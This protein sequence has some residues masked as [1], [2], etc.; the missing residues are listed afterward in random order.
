MA[1]IHQKLYQTKDIS[2]IDFGE[3]T[4]TV[5]KY[6][7]HSYGILHDKVKIKIDVQKTVMSIDSA[8]PAGLI[9]NELVSN[10]LKHAFP[11]ERKGN[12]FI[13]MAYD[14]FK[15]EYWLV[16]RDDGVGM[17]QDFDVKSSTSFGLK[18]VSTLVEQM[19]GQIELVSKGGC[20]YR[21]T[22]KS[23]DYTDRS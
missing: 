3:Y 20:E 23:A 19:G 2:H 17:V 4:E 9:I 15:S 14:Q 6:L 11:G 13:N 16:I 1:L 21:I 5:V 7:Q 22:F 18:L 10:A 12:I 8:I